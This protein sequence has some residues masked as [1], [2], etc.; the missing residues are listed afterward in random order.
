M[1]EH[2]FLVDSHI[3]SE[4]SHDSQCPISEIEQAAL[5]KG[6][7]LICI[8]DHCDLRV[9]CDLEEILQQ[10]RDRVQKIRERRQNPGG[11]QTLVGIEFG[12]AFLSPE[13]ADQVIR[14]EEYD[15]VIG[16]VHSV[17]LYGIS[18][19]TAKFDFSSLSQ[20]DLLAYLDSYL[21]AELC[22]AQKLN[23]D[24]LAHL[25]YLFRY[26]NGKHGLGLDWRVRE[27]KIR[28]ILTAVIQ[29]GI[30]YEINTSSWEGRYEQKAVEKAFVEMYLELGGQDIILGS[31]SH[32]SECLGRCFDEALAFLR[33]KGVDHLV[34]FAGRK[35]QTYPI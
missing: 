18:R 5:E 9:G 16:S 24:V 13:M 25:A 11:L 30:A 32:K 4:F 2:Q 7:N 15:V 23:V 33:S 26:V 22:I 19:P 34:Y 20:E 35:K 14:A 27:E 12:G 1:K 8:T 3:H 21:D 29:R 10:Q 28:R 6:L 31:D 17:M